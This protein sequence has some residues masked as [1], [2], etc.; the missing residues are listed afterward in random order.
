M[1]GTVTALAAVDRT[2]CGMSCLS[3]VPPTPRRRSSARDRIADEADVPCWSDAISASS[4]PAPT[5]RCRPHSLGPIATPP[6]LQSIHRPP[7]KWT[8]TYLQEQN[9][10]V[11]IWDFF[12]AL[13][14]VQSLSGWIP[15]YSRRISHQRSRRAEAGIDIAVS[16]LII[17][18]L[19]PR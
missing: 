13:L 7:V 5:P 2:L 8:R 3:S 4:K 14:I 16:E 9:P 19:V 15:L 17:D 6:A 11:G 1:G 10:A 12:Y 18:P